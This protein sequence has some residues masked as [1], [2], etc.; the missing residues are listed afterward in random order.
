MINFRWQSIVQFCR[1]LVKFWQCQGLRW[2]VG[3]C[4]LEILSGAARLSHD[5]FCMVKDLVGVLEKVHKVL[6]I[7][8]VHVI[9]WSQIGFLRSLGW[10]FA[11]VNIF[12]GR[13]CLSFELLRVKRREMN[14]IWYR[15]LFYFLILLNLAFYL[16]N[17]LGH[18]L[19][20]VFFTI[21]TFLLFLIKLLVI[22]TFIIT[23]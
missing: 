16:R 9:V 12:H 18:R 15:G 22:W 11:F 3:L 5:L 10:R 6:Y 8:W 19:L 13:I 14:R 2:L 23:L 20:R 1:G 4:C 7:G 17:R 21:L